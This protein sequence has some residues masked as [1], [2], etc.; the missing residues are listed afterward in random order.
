MNRRAMRM[1]IPN[2]SRGRDM[3]REAARQLAQER[4]LGRARCS[5]SPRPERDA[6]GWTRGREHAHV[7]FAVRLEK[8][9]SEQ[10]ETIETGHPLTD[11]RFVARNLGLLHLAVHGA[12][13]GRLSR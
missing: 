13:H 8:I 7:I 1:E 4:E 6:I 10:R 5:R 12:G 11:L 9:R 3:G 2:Y